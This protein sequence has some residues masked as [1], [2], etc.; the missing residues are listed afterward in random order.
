MA[1]ITAWLAG[2]NETITQG[3]GVCE[4]AGDCPHAGIDVAA[5]A[6]TPIVSQVW[7]TIKELWSPGA[8]GNESVID[9]GG[10]KTIVLG[11]QSGYAVPSGSQIR[12]GEVIG[13]VGSTGFST[14]PHLH[15][16]ERVGGR[17]VDPSSLLHAQGG[18]P[19]Q[20]PIIG[21]LINGA[22]QVGAVPGEVAQAVGQAIASVP[23]T[24]GHGIADAV[25][26]G[27]HDATVFAQRQIIALAVAAVVLLVLFLR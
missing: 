2:A 7:G 12:P 23:I 17:A 25:G 14:G 26:V 15:F 9:L 24:I 18:D 22:Q 13:Y 8:Y 10:G 27:V 11:H 19:T 20:I 4:L 16:E 1:D 3:F 5:P 6:G 21:G